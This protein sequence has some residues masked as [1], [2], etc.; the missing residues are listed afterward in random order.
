[1]SPPTLYQGAG[2][3]W[4][5]KEAL[6]KTGC[7]AAYCRNPLPYGE[8][9]CSRC[10]TARWR[11]RNPLKC[12]YKWIRE[13]A[14]RRGQEFTLSFREFKEILDGHLEMHLDRIDPSKGYTADNVQLL[15][16]RENLSKA[17][18][19]KRIHHY[20]KTEPLPF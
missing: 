4:Q 15:T 8:R 12:R 18:N 5:I 6:S 10:K 14:L 2:G 1:M 16:V 20:N 9:F 11:K 13:R 17:A 19:D 7:R 3:T